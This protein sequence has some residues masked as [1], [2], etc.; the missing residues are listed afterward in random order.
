VVRARGV[1]AGARG[2]RDPCAGDPSAGAD[3][4]SSDRCSLDG[5]S[6]RDRGRFRAGAD[7]RNPL[8]P[9]ASGSPAMIGA[10]LGQSTVR[11]STYARPTS[12]STNA[13]ASAGCGREV[14]GP[15]PPLV[16]VQATPSPQPSSTPGPAWSVHTGTPGP[17]PPPPAPMPVVVTA[18]VPPPPPPPPPPPS[19]PPLSR[20]YTRGGG[21]G[22]VTASPP[23]LAPSE[24]PVADLVPASP[25]PTGLSWPGVAAAAGGGFVLGLILGIVSGRMPKSKR[26]R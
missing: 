23:P 2:A 24:A 17:P 18:P 9:D 12:L 5:G 21:G 16:V 19:P 20:S 25:C 15:P 26:R 13:P 1:W 14:C 10:L 8:G 7:A 3:L 4:V 22:T 11:V 6:V